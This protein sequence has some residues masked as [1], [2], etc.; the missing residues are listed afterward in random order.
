MW[1]G[2]AA[3]FAGDAVV[4]AVDDVRAV[5]EELV[6]FNLLHGLRDGL[7]AEGAS[8]LF[9]GEELCGRCI[10]DEVDVGETALVT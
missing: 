2:A 7:G 9:Q 6:G 4:D 1:V 3:A 8:Y 5:S 10:L